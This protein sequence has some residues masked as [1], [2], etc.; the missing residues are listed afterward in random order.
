MLIFCQ[1]KLLIILFDK[2][3]HNA[4][5]YYIQMLYLIKRKQRRNYL[6]RFIFTRVLINV[7]LRNYFQKC[8]L[9]NA[10]QGP[11]EFFNGSKL[12]HISPYANLTAVFYSK[13][14]FKVVIKNKRKLKVLI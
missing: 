10:N 12:L 5:R 8:A 9:I 4:V 1:K 7:K 14:D 11:S 13:K 2:I 3:L 6:T